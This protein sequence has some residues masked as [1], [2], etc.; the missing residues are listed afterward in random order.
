MRAAKRKWLRRA[1]GD[2]ELAIA[3]YAVVKL[4]RRARRYGGW[5]FNRSLKFAKATPWWVGYA[6]RAAEAD[7][8]DAGIL[9]LVKEL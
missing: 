1:G 8:F 2:P 9:T 5:P 4:R 3:L 6:E 7:T